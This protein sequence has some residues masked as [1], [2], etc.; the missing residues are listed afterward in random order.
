M[1]KHSISKATSPEYQIR[2]LHRFT[3]YIEH[4]TVYE[5]S[6]FYNCTVVPKNNIIMYRNMG[7]FVEYE[8]R[9]I[10]STSTLHLNRLFV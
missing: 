6:D 9:S 10:L 8:D 5:D 1:S 4:G 7:N 3:G 2:S